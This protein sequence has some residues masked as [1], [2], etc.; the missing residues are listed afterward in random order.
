[1][2]LQQPT[3]RRTATSP[4]QQTH[5]TVCCNQGE[6]ATLSCENLFGSPRTLARVELTQVGTAERIWV[7]QP[8]TE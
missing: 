4:D 5:A 7:F 2:F 1:M 6:A 8:I 3:P